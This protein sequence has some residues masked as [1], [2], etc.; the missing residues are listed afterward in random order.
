MKTNKR[1]SPQGKALNIGSAAEPQTIQS[2]DSTSTQTSCTSE[3][4]RVFACRN[5]QS[6]KIVQALLLIIVIASVAAFFIFRSPYTY[7]A[8]F[9]SNNQVYFGVL[10]NASSKN[11]VLTDV[12]Y[13]S[14]NQQLAQGS[15]S[16]DQSVQLVKLGKELHEP[17]DKIVFNRE[18][19]LFTEPLLNTSRIVKAIEEFKKNNPK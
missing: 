5:K 1:Y 12:F 7:S 19:I 8:V 13:L 11:P 14:V 2:F 9:L 3:C 17:A 6:G 15:A 16:T 18:H 4:L 10:N